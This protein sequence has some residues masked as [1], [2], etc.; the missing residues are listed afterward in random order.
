MSHSL[1]IDVPEDVFS[2]LNKLALQQGKT[3]ETL[4]QE[5]VS[6]AVQE[7]EED[8]LLRWAG[9]IDS[10]ISD[11]AERHDYYIGQAL[12]RELRGNPDE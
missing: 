1:T 9:A 5:L 4:A 3:P 6:T 11:V 7:L 12:Y 2:Y 8:P 10:E